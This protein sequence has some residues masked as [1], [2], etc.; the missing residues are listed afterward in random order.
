M[1]GPES[2]CLST[3]IHDSALVFPD[4]VIA[5]IFLSFK[6]DN[7]LVYDFLEGIYLV[8]HVTIHKYL[9]KCS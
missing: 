8:K 2:K 4:D 1:P 6:F 3:H 9:L 5:L 7:L